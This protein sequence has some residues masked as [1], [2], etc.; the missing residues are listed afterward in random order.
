VESANVTM[1]SGIFIG[2]ASDTGADAASVI[3]ARMPE[4][5]D[6]AGERVPDT[7]FEQCQF[8]LEKAGVE[9][10]LPGVA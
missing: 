1:T 9:M 6:R 7:G 10:A 8:E 5:L 2:D 3:R 4:I